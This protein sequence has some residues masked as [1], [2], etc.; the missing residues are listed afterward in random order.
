MNPFAGTFTNFIEPSSNGA[1]WLGT[2]AGLYMVNVIEN[3]VDLYNQ[4]RGLSSDNIDA[5]LEINDHQLLIGTNK[6]FDIFNHRDNTKQSFSK[7]DG[8]S[9]NQTYGIIAG[10]TPDTYWISTILGLNFFNAKTGTFYNFFEKDGFSDNEFNRFAH[11][12]DKQGRY[13]F[14]GVNGLNSF[15]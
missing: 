15:L 7:K 1:L 11:Y 8:L 12:K 9:S 14:G 5:L 4:A 6:G 13:Y 2:M 3:T 10:E